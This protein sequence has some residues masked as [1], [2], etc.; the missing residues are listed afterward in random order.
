MIVKA[1]G[2]ATGSSSCVSKA[3]SKAHFA[4][5]HLIAS[6][7]FARRCGE[8][9]RLHSSPS[10]E[11]QAEHRSCVTGAVLCAASALEAKINEVFLDGIDKNPHTFKVRDERAMEVMAEFWP[12]LENKRYSTLRKYQ[13]ALAI[14]GKPTFKAGAPLYQAVDDLMQLRNALVHFKPE[15]TTESG[16]HHKLEARLIRKFTANPFAPKAAEFFPRRCLSHGCAAWA[17]D[18]VLAFIDEFE[19]RLQ[20]GQK[21]DTYKA[22]LRTH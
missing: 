12:E 14:F 15:W 8:L 4:A 1:Q 19:N 11:I 13:I 7:F 5:N 17:V 18:S 10:E 16:E 2:R 3:S 9:E 22:R 21:L 6:A 20:L